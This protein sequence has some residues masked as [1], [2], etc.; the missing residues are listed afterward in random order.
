[1]LENGTRLN[2]SDLKE[3]FT[4]TVSVPIRDL[5]LANF[6]YAKQFSDNGFDIY[7][8]NS[9]F[10]INPCTS[11]Y[12]HKDD[13]PLKDR[14]KDIYPNVTLCKGSNFFIKKQI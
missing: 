11:A 1:M 10:Y 5:D 12:L 3:D 7:D 13:I 6:N 8:K 14:K 4:V 2:L 9:D